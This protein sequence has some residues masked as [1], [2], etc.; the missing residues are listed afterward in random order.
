[1]TR[2]GL[3]MVK[4]GLALLA[5]GVGTLFGYVVYV[6]LRGLYTKPDAPLVLQVVVP[7]ALVGLALLVAAVVRDRLRTLRGETF[8]EVEN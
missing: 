8:K 6:L 2:G 3:V 7:V 1:M 4:V 5:V